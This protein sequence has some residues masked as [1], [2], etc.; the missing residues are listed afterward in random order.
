MVAYK[1]F[2]LAVI[3]D[4]QQGNAHVKVIKPK[5]TSVS[6]GEERQLSS[7]KSG[8]T[9]GIST[10][11]NLGSHPQAAIMG[12]AMKTN[13]KT[14]GFEKTQNHSAIT[15]SV[16]RSDGN[17]SWGFN[18]AD[19]SIQKQGIDMQEDDLPTVRFEFA[20]D[21]DLPEPPPKYM[22]IAIISSWSIIP[23]HEVSDSE[24]KS[25][26]L[27]KLLRFFRSTSKAQTT[28][29]SNLCQIVAL[30]VDPSNL[31]RP[32]RYRAKVEVRSGV[33]GP[34]DV[35]RQ[36]ADSVDVTFA[37]VDSDGRYITADLWT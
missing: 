22:D 23:L 33:C 14:A 27:H 28:S 31:P 17:V 19:V 5:S 9:C 4:S 20:G 3:V 6:G 16:H 8:W 15:A 7:T 18:I 26:W 11:L 12:V 32:S 25:A 29:Y 2:H 1:Q 24:P 13:E 30:K 34:P 21:S 10:G 35:K 37:V 36:A